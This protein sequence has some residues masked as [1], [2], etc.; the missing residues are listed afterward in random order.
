MGAH[1]CRTC[2]AE[3][4][5]E[6]LAPTPELSLRGDVD[7]QVLT[8]GKLALELRECTSRSAWAGFA[9]NDEPWDTVWEA[10]EDEGA[11]RQLRFSLS[12]S[13]EVG[14]ALAVL[15]DPHPAL[16]VAHADPEGQ[17][18]RSQDGG[19]GV[20]PGDTVLEV[21][22]RAGSADELFDRLLSLRDAPGELQLLVRPRPLDN[23]SLRVRL[24]RQG[25]DWRRLGLSVSLQPKHGSMLIARVHEAGLV[26]RW[27]ER[28]N[29]HCVCIG[30]RIVAVNSCH[31][32]AYAMYAL[33]QA[34][35]LGGE[36]ELCVEPPPR[37]LARA[38]EAWALRTTSP[39]SEESL[40]TL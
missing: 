21:Q 8:R 34:T 32:S 29:Q 22:D 5:S 24:V 30:D 40:E 12:G 35:G 11:P 6:D 36:I 4:L 3:G 23:G 1:N 27:N 39:D 38:L 19:P 28:N 25:P 15:P 18:S 10:C 13:R 7:E 20:C 26:P 33:V 2:N 17:L 9:L 37:H 16:V 31:S 14:L